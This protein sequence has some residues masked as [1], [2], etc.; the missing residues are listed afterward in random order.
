MTEYVPPL[1]DIRF[2]LEQLVD[3][4]GLAKLEAYAHADPGT[5]LGVIE[6]AGQ[7]MA[8]VVGPINRV[9]DTAGSTLDGEGDVTTPPG[10]KEA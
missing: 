7:F 4:D 5:V 1:R 8:E 9:G 10:F 3:L 6:E 2:V